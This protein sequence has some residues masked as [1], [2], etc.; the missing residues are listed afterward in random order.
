MNPQIAADISTWVSL[1]IQCATIIT[2][3]Y[4]L[5]KFMSK[6]AETQNE[7]ID[8]LERWRAEV[9][10]RLR[11]GSDHFDRIDKGNTVTQ[12][13]ILALIEHALNGNDV[14]ALRDAKK[15]LNEYLMENGNR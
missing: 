13:A 6:P 12:K 10:A 3:I 4:T 9:D 1:I 8:A 15:E 2:L 11:T 5:A 14:G 7:R